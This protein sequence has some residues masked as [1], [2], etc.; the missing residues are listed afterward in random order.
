MFI[1][2]I[3][4]KPALQRSAMFRAATTSGSAGAVINCLGRGYKH[5][6]PPGPKQGSSNT[7][8]HYASLWRVYVSLA[9]MLY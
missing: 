5:W 1:V 9:I 2:I 6:V 4:L 3:P 8:S 7:L